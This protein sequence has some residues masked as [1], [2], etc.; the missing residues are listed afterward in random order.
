MRPPWAHQ[1][2]TRPMEPGLSYTREYLV[3]LI[4]DAEG[5]TTGVHLYH[6]P[7]TGKVLWLFT[8]HERGHEFMSALM[9][10]PGEQKKAFMEVLEQGWGRLGSGDVNFGGHFSAKTVPE[11]AKDL[12]RWKVDRLIVDPGFP[13]W[14]QRIYASPYKA[15]TE[16]MDSAMSQASFEELEDGTLYAEIPGFRGVWAS[17]EDVPAAS[18][19]LREVLRDWIGLRTTRG[20]EIPTVIDVEALA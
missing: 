20:L 19:E 15:L 11:M 3:P 4:T 16:Y 13:G 7:E 12:E 10:D 9:A 6:R 8:S 17:G 14:R 5:K 2:Y 18:E 1:G